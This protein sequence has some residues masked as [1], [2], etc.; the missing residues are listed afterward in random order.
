[1]PEYFNANELLAN[2]YWKDKRFEW[3]GDDLIYMGTNRTSKASTSEK[4]WYIWKLT[5]SGAD[6][7]R[8]QGP[9]EGSWDDR[10]TLGW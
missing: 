5:W 8:L 1:M 4:N 2:S 10:A 7:I 9:L 6:L 3:S